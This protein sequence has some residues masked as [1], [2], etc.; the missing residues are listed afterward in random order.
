MRAPLKNLLPCLLIPALASCS[1]ARVNESADRVEATADSASTI[2]AQMR[3]TRPDRRDTVVFSDKPW[4][5]TKP[6]SVSHTL[7]SDCIVTW[8]PAGAASLQEA[9]QEVINQCHLAVSITPDALNPAAF[10]LQPQQR[11]SNAPPPIQG[12]QDMA[13]MLFPA[14]VANGMSLGAGGSMGSSFGSYGPRSLYNIKWNG[15]V[16]GFLDLIAARA[17]V[18]WRYNPTE[19]R[20][21]FYYLDTRTFRIYAFDDVNTVDSTVRS[22][23]TTAAGISGDGSGSTGQNGSSG[24]SGDSG[25]KQTTSSELKTS[26]L[27]D[28]ENSINS[29]LTPSMGRMSLSRAT[30]TL[31]VTDR[32]E[33]L[34]RVQQLVNRENESITKQVLLNVNVLSVALTDKDQLG[35]DWNLVYKSLNNKWGIGLKNTMPGI[36]QSA[37]SGS[38]SILDTANS[39]WAGS[40]AMVQALA[41]QGRVSTVRSPSVTTLNLQSAPI[42]IGRYDSYLASSQISNVA[43]V[44]STTSLIP[45]AVT[46]GYNMSLLPFVMESGEML[47]KININMTSRPTF[48]MQTSGDSKAQ[49][50]SYDIQLFDQ[51]VRLRSGETLVLS[52]F[53]QTT[54]DTYKVGTGDAGFFGLGGGLTRNTKREVIVVLI[55]PVVL[56]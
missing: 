8:R 37:I 7:S 21:E 10:A 39:A 46:S 29:M 11:A 40:K 52:G 22:G 26:I 23:M 42:Q 15:K 53:D 6:L 38:V 19:K 30:G 56:G 27:S 16:S 36:D 44:G 17:G 47:L 34:N 41:Q 3:N 1:V 4:V 33:V 32:P 48:E 24:I 14:S 28:I 55:T 45:G 43:Q 13:T 18:S 50:P 12:G 54:E 9:A 31:T 51:K 5:S 2:A 25:S 49:F 35:I 20:V